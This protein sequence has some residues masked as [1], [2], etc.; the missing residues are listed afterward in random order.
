MYGHFRD[1][2]SG[3]VIDDGLA[4]L[5][6]AP[7]SYTGEDVI[8]LQGHGGTRSLARLLECVVAAGARPASRASS[9]C[10]RSLASGSI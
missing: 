4:I 3:K 6:T 5:M 10:G 7:A 1:N 2:R 8:E 9:P